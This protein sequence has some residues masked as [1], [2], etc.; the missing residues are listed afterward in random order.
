MRHK[1][2]LILLLIVTLLLSV[3]GTV[4]AEAIN[5][6][7]TD[8][9]L[10][11]NGNRV[12]KE[13]LIV[14]GSSYLP[15]RA[16][17]EALGLEVDYNSQEKAIYLSQDSSSTNGD[18]AIINEFG[19][20]EKLEE[21]NAELKQKIA[22]LENELD[23]F[24][25]VQDTTGN[26]VY[27]G[28]GIEPFNYQT[29]YVGN[30]IQIVKN[31]E[32]LWRTS[33][34]LSDTSYTKDNLKNQYNNYILMHSNTPSGFYL[35]Y[36]NE[37]WQYMEFP[38][39]KKYKKFKATLGLTEGTSDTKYKITLEIYADGKNIYKKEIK[40]GDFPSQID[41]D[42]SGVEKLKI[43][44]ISTGKSHSYEGI[45]LFNARFTK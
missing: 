41:L 45:G 4:L 23:G 13:I 17:S 2:K 29:G 34:Q 21:E 18:S 40:A 33:N 1:K 11:L 39:L 42:I 9:K 7:F 19:I 5:A 24:K 28:D 38:T 12:D 8:L 10:F 14:D 6:S 37:R 20:L 36:E 16:L 25:G 43:K 30:G 31:G 26:I 22:D 44:I 35:I 32:V 15:L 27:A 3:G